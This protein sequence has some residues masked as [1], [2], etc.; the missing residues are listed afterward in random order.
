MIRKPIITARKPHLHVWV[1][2]PVQLALP[3]F[4]PGAPILPAS[5]LTHATFREM[6][7]PVLEQI[8]DGNPKKICN[9]A[10]FPDR[11]TPAA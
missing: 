4:L 11:N 3:P 2:P 6:G 7:N 10:Q 1:Q 8:R 9:A 5:P